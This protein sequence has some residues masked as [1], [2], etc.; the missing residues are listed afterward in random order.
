[1]AELF[2]G[3]SRARLSLTCLMVNEAVPT[4]PALCR[5]AVRR[6]EPDEPAAT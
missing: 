1:M 2:V 4:L 3:V 6:P 5:E